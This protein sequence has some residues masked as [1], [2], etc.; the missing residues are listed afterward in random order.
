MFFQL[1]KLLLFGIGGLVPCLVSYDCVKK[2]M[3]NPYPGDSVTGF[4]FCLFFTSTAYILAFM[5][6]LKGL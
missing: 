2:A 1:F 3:E 6:L 4:G 5:L